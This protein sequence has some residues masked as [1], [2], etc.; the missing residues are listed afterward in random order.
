[1]YSYFIIKKALGASK[2]A[3]NLWQ[4]VR[5]ILLLVFI[6][7]ACT[8]FIWLH[9]N[10][11]ELVSHTEFSPYFFFV[12]H[13]MYAIVLLI[14]S[15]HFW[16]WPGG[17]PLSENREYSTSD[18]NSAS[19]DSSGRPARHRTYTAASSRISR[20]GKSSKYRF[21]TKI[22]TA[23][24]GLTEQLIPTGM[25]RAASDISTA[26]GLYRAESGLSRPIHVDTTA[27]NAPRTDAAVIEISTSIDHSHV[28][29]TVGSLQSSNDGGSKGFIH[30]ADDR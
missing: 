16:R 6:S 22:S 21:S 19:A 7:L 23:N 11:A 2:R 12:F 4:K 8:I 25:P 30:R 29:D 15:H 17:Q 28:V 5:G 3:T 20:Q 27:S 10:E 14:G 13:I 24:R 18:S 9:C 1:M 26:S